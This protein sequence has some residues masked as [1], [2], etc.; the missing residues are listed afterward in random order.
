ME[1]WSPIPGA[2]VRLCRPTSDDREAFVEATRR[3]RGLHRPWVHPPTTPSGFDA[4][5]A[6]GEG[7]RRERWL[8]W[9][10][11]DGGLAGYVAANEI[12][13]GALQSAYLGYW[14][15]EGHA[16]RGLMR[17]ALAAAVG[18]WLGRR[19]FRL[20][21]LEANIQ[22]ANG[23]SRALVESLGFRLEGL[24]PRYLKVAGRWRD[25]ERW[26]ITV[27]DWRRA[28]ARAR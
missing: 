3:S 19:R 4:W 24:S 6:E 21:R 22:P 14:A 2:R 28:R 23:R 12:V 16:G 1:P 11:A 26:A 10:R 15:V 25:H 27:E 9:D 8:V 18:H 7:P 17:E 5:L 13:Y 20:H